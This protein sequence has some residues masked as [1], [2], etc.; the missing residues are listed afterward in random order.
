MDYAISHAQ[1]YDVISLKG[2]FNAETVNGLR[3][4]LDHLLKDCSGDVV[5][6]MSSVEKLDSS[7]IGVLVFLYKRLKIEK[8]KLT[9]VGV[10]AKTDELLSMLQINKTIRQFSDLDDYLSNL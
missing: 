10:N 1:S 6:D 2:Q 7:G 5:I 4:H 9:L 3:S 8:R